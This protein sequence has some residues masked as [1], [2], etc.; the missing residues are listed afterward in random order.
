[1]PTT[2]LPSLTA[3]ALR[4]P[5]LGVTAVALMAA[6]S[7][8]SVALE[9]TMTLP[10]TVPAESGVKITLKEVLCPGV[11]VSGVVIPEVVRPVPA[12]VT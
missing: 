4:V 3:V 12:I 9:S 7:A 5:E 1:M 2:T 11:K 10:L 8:G 6:L